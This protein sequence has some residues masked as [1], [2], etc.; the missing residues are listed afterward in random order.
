MQAPSGPTP[1]ASSNVAAAIGGT[2]TQVAGEPPLHIPDLAPSTEPDPSPG[3]SNGKDKDDQATLHPAQVQN[4][5]AQAL[6]GHTPLTPESATCASVIS[7]GGSSQDFDFDIADLSDFL[8]QHVEDPA[9]GG[10]TSGTNSVAP[11]SCEDTA[12]ATLTNQS[13]ESTADQQ[14]E[15][16]PEAFPTTLSLWDQDA[17]WESLLGVQATAPSSSLNT[18]QL[19]S[20]PVAS[21]SGSTSSPAQGSVSPTQVQQDNV[22]PDQDPAILPVNPSEVQALCPIQNSSLVTQENPTPPQDNPVPAQLG[23]NAHLLMP[24]DTSQPGSSDG[25]LCSPKH[26]PAGHGEPGV[27]ILAL[28]LMET[29]GQDAKIELTDEDSSPSTVNQAANSVHAESSQDL[30]AGFLMQ[31]PQ[32]PEQQQPIHLQNLQ[33]PPQQHVAVSQQK[34]GKPSYVQMIVQVSLSAFTYC[35]K[36]FHITFECE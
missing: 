15:V 25:Q 4:T 31:Q 8:S 11:S 6:G 26:A 5:K 1:G 23:A 34:N 29:F 7:S 2:N 13:P 27:D 20:V 33:P 14:G 32:C 10:T 36:D 17:R 18:D 28:A 22:T 24:G 30:P 16:Q 21:S 19:N 3:V 12:T 35:K 9:A